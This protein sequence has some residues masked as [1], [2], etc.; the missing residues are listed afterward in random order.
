MNLPIGILVLLFGLLSW[1]IIVCVPQY[2]GAMQKSRREL[3]EVFTLAVATVVIHGYLVLP[4]ESAVE[5][6]RAFSAEITKAREGKQLVYYNFGPDGDELKYLLNLPL[7][8]RFIGEYVII[9][10]EESQPEQSE[11]QF[12]QTWVEK[13]IALF[14]E[15]VH[16]ENPPLLPRYKIAEEYQA[17]F[18]YPEDTFFLTREKYFNR[19][20]EAI[21]NAFDV[22]VKGDLGHQE[23]LVFRRKPGATMPELQ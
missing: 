8:E 15:D 17:L 20:P 14:P 19:T 16:T 6:S 12:L 5:S 11:E 13:L 2:L 3:F 10:E 22:V 1:G 21:R 18:E 7:E 4:I 23:C 9:R